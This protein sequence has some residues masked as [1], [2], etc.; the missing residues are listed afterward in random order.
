MSISLLI[1]GNQ[2]P[3]IYYEQTERKLKLSNEDIIHWASLRVT[4]LETGHI[5]YEMLEALSTQLLQEISTSIN[6][7]RHILTVVGG[8]VAKSCLTLCDPMDCNL[9]GS[10]VHGISQ[11]R[12]LEWV[13]ISFPQGRGYCACLCAKSLQPCPTLCNSMDCSPPGSSSPWNSL[14]KNTGVGCHVLLIS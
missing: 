5:P 14:D 12:I 4:S 1:N 6:L 9:P 7:V 11:A 8:A 10:F 13:A 2:S 3:V